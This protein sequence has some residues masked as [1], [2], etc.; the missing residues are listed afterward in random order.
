VSARRFGARAA[1]AVLALAS[2]GVA[3]GSVAWAWATF[4][5]WETVPLIP[6]VLAAGS[7]AGLAVYAAARRL[8]VAVAIGALVSAATFIGTLV[9]TLARWEG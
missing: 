7:L 8:G 3:I 4:D 9:V 5:F 6:C 1:A 2:A